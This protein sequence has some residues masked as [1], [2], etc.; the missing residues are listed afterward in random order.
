MG[1][2]VQSLSDG[3]LHGGGERQVEGEGLSPGGQQ[4]E[5]GGE[6][7]QHHA[8]KGPRTTGVHCLGR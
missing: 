3:S 1:D 4:R 7:R 2:V 6:R 5:R 8:A